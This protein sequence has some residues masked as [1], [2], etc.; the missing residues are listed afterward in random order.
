MAPKQLRI[1]LF[2]LLTLSAIT[3]GILA[4][5]TPDSP[6]GVSAVAAAAG[7][8]TLP[9]PTTNPT[10]AQTLQ[11]LR[12]VAGL[13]SST[14]MSA[15]VSRLTGVYDFVRAEGGASSV[16]VADNPSPL[17]SPE[18]RAR[19]FLG[20]YGGLVGMTDAE[21]N[22]VKTSGAS[23]TTAIASALSLT[24]V[25]TDSLGAS[26]VKFD[27]TYQG[28]KVFGAQVVVHMNAFG[29][30]GIN[31]NFIPNVNLSKTPKVSAA[32]AGRI[33]VAAASKTPD[34]GVKVS[35]TE[36]AVYRM[37]LLEGYKGRNVLAYAVEV[38]GPSVREQVWVNA[39]TGN[40]ILRVPRTEGVLHRIVYTPTY[41][42]SNPNSNKIREEGDPTIL[43]PPSNPPDNLYHYAGQTYNLYKS[44]FGRESYDGIGLEPQRTVLLVN[45]KC[46]N[47]YWDGTTTNYCPDFDKDDVV[48]HEWTHAYTQYTDNLIY[49]YQ[50]GALNESWSDIFGEAV[51]LNNGVDGA[52]G[53][54]NAQP[55]TY[56]LQGGQYTPTGGGVRWRMG[57]DL[58]GL[59]QPAALGILRDMWFPEAFGDPGKV[60]SPS[61]FCGTGDG[62]GV[63]TNSGVPN[64]A[65]ALMVDGTSSLPD[66]KF[67][68]VAVDAIG[69]TRALAIYF[70]AMT[71]YQTTSTNF[72]QHA[73]AM[74]ASCTDLIG[75]PLNNFSTSTAVGTPSTETITAATCQ[76]VDNAMA[77][78]EMSAPPKQCGF[79]KLLDPDTPEE[80]TGSSTF[81]VEDWETGMDGW[82]LGT[83]GTGDAWTGTNWTLKSDLPAN[84]DGSPHTGT[85]A[86]AVNPPIGEPGGGTCSAGGDVS[87]HF[88]IDSPEIVI[89]AGAGDP[90]LAFEHFV[91]T[92]TGFD[93]GN[94]KVS[95][96]GGPFTVVPQDQY[97][98][99]RPNFTGPSGMPLEGEP[100]WNGAN[101]GEVTGSWGTTIVSL[102]N[103]TSPGDR[104]KIRFDFGQDG[105]NGNLGWY[106]D[107]IRLFNCPLLDA[108]VLTTGSDYGNP[109]RDGKFTL[110][111]TRPAGAVGPDLL[112]E[113][114]ACGPVF[115]DDASETLLAGAN[116]KWT[117]AAQW[118]SQPNPSTTS[119]S[120]FIPDGAAQDASLAMK[121]AVAIPASASSALTFTTR[122]GLE[123]GFDFGYVEVSTDGGTTYTTI[124]SYT[125]PADAIEPTTV[126]EGTRTVN[127][128]QFAGQSIKVR[129]RVTSDAFNIGQPAGW[130]IDDIAI[131]ATTFQNTAANIAGNS[132]TFTHKA[133]GNFCYRVRTKYQFG[134]E[135]ADSPFSNLTNVSVANI[136]CLTNVAASANGATATASSTYS[137]RSY[138][139]SSAIDG[140]RKGANWEQGG[141]WNDATRDSFPD[142]LEVD[143]SGAKRIHQINVF[144]LQDSFT[145]PSDPTPLMTCGLYGLLDFQVQ[146]WDGANWATVPGGSITNNN[147]VM[148]TILFEDIT[149]TKIR[150]FVTNA[151][152]HFSRITEVEAIGCDAQP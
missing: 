100:I 71:T 18:T 39:N 59:S 105:C 68:G 112:Q 144:T 50:P 134:Q 137:S 42:P 152:E 69:F 138:P 74:H 79:Q 34:E 64:H 20:S 57:E 126:F 1:A 10:A 53:S 87:G 95:V 30:K 98:F 124:A 83:L 147:L 76:A 121:N 62:G 32:R 96:N 113:S 43:P 38:A 77:A 4:S 70:R 60:S 16:L 37:G 148:N 84:L 55:T 47:A 33:A 116:S 13:Q 82:T 91:Q 67:N 88:W 130:Y 9:Q 35:K 63:H 142:W 118:S 44:G 94:V 108:P 128:S 97:V 90:K 139:A 103:L 8:D 21:R 129:F 24:S 106:V 7:Q 2:S 15:S 120:Y 65:F 75:A 149:T 141:G 66:G 36:L 49:A 28:L 22:L 51:D 48:S 125:G 135:L 140:D 5:A 93:G 99:N 56:T 23:T 107:T 26:H 131:T 78:V 45:D 86:F 109:D 111:W 115:T 25:Y 19:N 14:Q 102:A 54:N 123:D 6:V 11:K 117:G 132:Y 136:V 73:Q 143:F 101:G 27:Q 85:A 150:V 119:T 145:S 17:T 92:E 81:F 61:Y 40:V 114:T 31:G 110:N 58:A 151:R 12:T 89:P 80:C 146:Y 29:I 127:L 3:L 46:P 52:G 104:I 72:A 41:D 133:D 122:Q